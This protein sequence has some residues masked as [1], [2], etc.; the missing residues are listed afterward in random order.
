M[1]Y[2]AFTVPRLMNPSW[3]KIPEERSKESMKEILKAKM[4]IFEGLT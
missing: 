1:I 3:R 2:L 4:A